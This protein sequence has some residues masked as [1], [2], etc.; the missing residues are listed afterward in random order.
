LH[1]L[2]SRNNATPLIDQY[3][4]EG[5]SGPK[6]WKSRTV[7][8]AHQLGLLDD[9]EFLAVG[10]V[11]EDITHRNPNSQYRRHLKATC[12]RA[13]DQWLQLNRQSEAAQALSELHHSLLISVGNS[14]QLAPSS[15]AVTHVVSSS[16]QPGDASTPLAPLASHHMVDGDGHDVLSAHDDAGDDHDVPS[17][18]DD[19]VMSVPALDSQPQTYFDLRGLVAGSAAWAAWQQKLANYRSTLSHTAAS[20]AAVERCSVS[21]AVLYELGELMTEHLMNKLWR[22]ID[23]NENEQCGKRVS[24]YFYHDAAW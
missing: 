5:T 10:I 6:Q 11:S 18:H 19:D 16:A 15:L 17:S 1:L 13:L 22:C 8:V 4:L 9:R 24:V 20:S 7:I 2:L 3:F 21:P 14:G 23:L 12:Q